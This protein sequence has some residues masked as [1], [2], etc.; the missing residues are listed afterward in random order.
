MNKYENAVNQYMIINWP[1]QIEINFD[2]ISEKKIS[3]DFLQ[4]AQS[5]MTNFGKML[6]YQIL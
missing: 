4:A 3:A 5:C 6:P 2:V 1:N